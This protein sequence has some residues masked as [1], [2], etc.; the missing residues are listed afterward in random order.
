MT[1]AKGTIL[2][3]FCARSTRVWKFVAAAIVVLVVCLPLMPQSNEGRISGTVFDQSGGAIA[4]A[5]VTV[6]DVARGVSRPLTADGVGAYSAPNLQPGTYTVRAEANG[7]QAT[8]HTGV[9]VEVGQDIRVDLTLQAG[10]QA[11]TVTVTGEVP[12]VETTNA[13]LGGAISNQTINDLPLNGRDFTRLIQLRPGVVSY[14]GGGDHADSTNGQT[15]NMGVYLIDGLL[16]YTPMNGGGA[17]NYRYQAGGSSTILPID[18]IQEFNVQENPKSEY[19]WAIGAITNVGL[20]AGTNSIH[21]TGYA[22]GR[23]DAWDARTFTNPAT[24]S[25]GAPNPKTPVALKQYGATAGGPILK[26]RLFWFVGYE[27]QRY[28]VGDEYVGAAPVSVSMTALGQAVDPTKSIV[29]ACNALNPNHLPYVVG[30]S[31]PANG[32]KVN[33]LSAQL[34]G[35]TTNCTVSGP[36]SAIENLFPFN[37]GNNPGGATV[38]A[39]TLTNSSPSDNGIAKFDYHLNDHNSFSASYFRGQL[40]NAVWVTGPDQLTSQMQNLISV[41]NWDAGLSWNYT[42]NSTWVNELRVGAN[43]I[44]ET[45]VGADSNANQASPWPAG[46]GI[47]TGVTNPLYYGMPYLQ[48]SNL[49]NFAL[50]H[51]N[52]SATRGPGGLNQLIDNV[53]YLRGKHAFK[54]GGNFFRTILDDNLYNA[55]QGRITFGSI[56]SYLQGSPSRG[57]IALGNIQY[58]KRDWDYAFFAQDDWRATTRVTVN[59]GLRWEYASPLTDVDNLFGGFNPTTGLVQNPTVNPDYRNFSP[60][61]GMAWDVKGNGKTVVRSA[62]SLMYPTAIFSTVT[63]ATGNPFG[64]DQVVKGVTTPGSQVGSGSVAYTAAQLTWTTAGPVFPIT[65][66]GRLACGDGVKP[67]PAQCNAPF[68]DPNIRTPRMLNW[69]LDVQR[70]LTNNLTLDLAYVG[71]HASGLP[72]ALDINAPPIGAGWFGPSGAAAACLA[73]APTGY[74]NCNVSSADEIAARPFNKAFP[75]LQFINEL[76]NRDFS[77]YNGLQATLT[78]RPLHGLYFLAGYTYSHAL[79]QFSSPPPGR[80]GYQDPAAPQLDYG[81]SDYDLRHRF[82]FSLTYNLPSR[83]APGQMLQGWVVNSVVTLQTGMPWSTMDTTNDFFGNLEN[84]NSA[85]ERWDFTGNPADFK[86]G[87]SNF[88]CFSA[89]TPGNTVLGSC[90]PYA[91]GVPPAICLQA[92][93]ANGQLAVASLYNNGCYVSGNSVIAPP[94]YGSLGTMARGIFRDGGFRNWDLSV[95]KDWKFKE[96]LTT[97][98]RAEFFN[99]LNHPNFANPYGSFTTYYNNDPSG[100]LGFGCGCVTP[101]AAAGNFVLGAGGARDIQ[102]GLKLIF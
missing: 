70:A 96:R 99:I 97:Q 51:G 59:L 66:N 58:R 76:G 101:D 54:F 83:K 82:T 93:Q 89:G 74:S 34:A 31:A 28:T 78:E 57:S 16:N 84:K 63:G 10:S 47:N 69:N 15:A 9:L 91:G 30:T 64:F 62:F 8:Q 2:V 87:P 18:A 38:F 29:D 55:A 40:N 85:Q 102:L 44:T 45:N 100:G 79:D 26:D 95:V 92:A 90:T 60:R 48:I 86:S 80:G 13:T 12:D 61:I 94:A 21:G 75:Y 68:V 43:R 72:G 3:Q 32:N 14:P 39:P 4:G 36:S 53:S 50:G 1:S 35:L 6:T 81:N 27:G 65:T 37:P 5:M 88:S 7:F 20:K 56:S 24:L 77:N 19:G 49:T 22:F 33:A 98:F 73:S 67:D 52:T 23:D 11:Q 46:F 17:L 25:N 41:T 42:P 71:N